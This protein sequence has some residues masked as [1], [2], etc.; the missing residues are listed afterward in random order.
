MMAM[1]AMMA[2]AM[3]RR[4]QTATA[5]TMTAMRKTNTTPRASFRAA[6]LAEAV[7]A[8]VAW[9][10]SSVV[11]IN[12]ILHHIYIVNM[13]ILYHIIPHYVVLRVLWPSLGPRA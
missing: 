12:R 10:C 9:R 3:M 11:F 4:M 8:A 6:A 2:M 7:G 1:M 5:M 13:Y